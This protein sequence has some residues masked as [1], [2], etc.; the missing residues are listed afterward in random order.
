MQA[1]QTYRPTA[2]SCRAGSFTKVSYGADSYLPVAEVGSITTHN[3]ELFAAVRRHNVYNIYVFSR[4]TQQVLRKIPGGRSDRP[5]DIRFL[6]TIRA[7]NGRL[8]VFDH[9]EGPRLQVLTLTGEPVCEVRDAEQAQL[10]VQGPRNRRMLCPLNATPCAVGCGAAPG[11]GRVF[12]VEHALSRVC[13]PSGRQK[14]VAANVWSV[15]VS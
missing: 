5:G 14:Q 11:E 4:A 1:H 9:F 3:D 15:S 13:A 10:W 2:Q 7:V 6:L 12:L 8:L